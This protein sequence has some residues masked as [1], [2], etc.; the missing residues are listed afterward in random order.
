MLSFPRSCTLAQLPIQIAMEMKTK[1]A[2][3]R[4]CRTGSAN[5]VNVTKTR[6]H[7]KQQES[8]IETEP[9]LQNLSLTRNQ[10]TKSVVKA[11]PKMHNVS[12]TQNKKAKMSLT[13][14]KNAQS[15]VDTEPNLQIL[16]LR[17]KQKCKICHWHRTKNANFTSLLLT[18]DGI[19]YILAALLLL[20]IIIFSLSASLSFK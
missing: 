1:F 14:T 7:S 13:W 15:V 19:C 4:G 2:K 8:I 10:N 9:K 11:K 20:W 6:V 12:L 16:S 17:Q 18:G 3:C 5:V